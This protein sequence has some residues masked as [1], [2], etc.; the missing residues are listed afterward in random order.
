MRQIKISEYPVGLLIP[1]ERY[2]SINHD[3][4]Y[5]TLTSYMGI[6][7][8]ELSN[9]E[10]DK[11]KSNVPYNIQCSPP[12][13]EQ[14]INKLQKVVNKWKRKQKLLENKLKENNHE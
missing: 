7:F 14:K 10:W 2:Y 1:M 3:I 11:I 6:E 9:K 8:E 5:Q 12:V 13:W 4:G